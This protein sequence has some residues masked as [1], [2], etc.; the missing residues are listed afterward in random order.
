MF[1][2]LRVARGSLA[3]CLPRDRKK[4]KDGEGW[5]DYCV[6]PGG[7]VTGPGGW[8][9]AGP[10]V[11]VMVMLAVRLR[12][13]RNAKTPPI[14]AAIATARNSAVRIPEGVEGWK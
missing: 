3:C 10:V 11:P 9:G 1:S 8:L 13:N 12:L 2:Q 4:G 5:I 14:P 7:P 6:G